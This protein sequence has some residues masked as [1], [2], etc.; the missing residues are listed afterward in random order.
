MFLLCLF[1]FAL[2]VSTCTV[3]LLLLRGR[4]VPVP[5]TL[6]NLVLSFVSVALYF[7]LILLSILLSSFSS[8]GR[9]QVVSEAGAWSLARADPFGFSLFILYYIV[10][11]A[12]PPRGA[13]PIAGEGGG[14]SLRWGRPM[15]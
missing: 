1:L 11:Q 12:G 7:K 13:G 6:S 14:E 15:S 5:M 9:S 10:A 4:C 8:C 2:R 3:S